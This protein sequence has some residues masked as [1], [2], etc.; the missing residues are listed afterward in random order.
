MNI[1]EIIEELKTFSDEDL[2]KF[3]KVFSDF[4]KPYKK[5]EYEKLKKAE[6]IKAGDK[7]CEIYGINAYPISIVH[8][9]SDYPFNEII[10]DLFDNP[11][12]GYTD[13]D[14]ENIED[15]FY[16]YFDNFMYDEDMDSRELRPGR[17][18]YR[19]YVKNTNGE[20]KDIDEDEIRT[21]M[22]G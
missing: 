16:E 21:F 22:Q 2:I 4:Y 5:K 12:K 17:S 19:V 10:S 8:K 13:E 20:I 15:T 1:N 14:I 9:S 7:L 18:L 11:A 3:N 6:A